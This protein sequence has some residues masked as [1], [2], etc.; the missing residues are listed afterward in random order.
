M[1]KR[2]HLGFFPKLLSHLVSLGTQIRPKN[3]FFAILILLLLGKVY[4]KAINFAIAE[5]IGQLLVL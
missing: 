2:K 1:E 4:P 5:L 3:R